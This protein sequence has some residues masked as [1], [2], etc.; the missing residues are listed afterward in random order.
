MRLAG[1]CGL[2]AV[3]PLVAG[4]LGSGGDADDGSLTWTAP[5]SAYAVT[6]GL[7]AP[8]APKLTNTLHLLEGQALGTIKPDSYQPVRIPV[9]SPLGQPGSTRLTVWNFTW[10]ADVGL[11]RGVLDLAVEVQ[12]FVAGNPYVATSG[13]DSCFWFVYVEVFDP[14]WTTVER[15]EH[16][17]TTP[18]G[19]EPAV[20]AE[21]V[22]RLHLPFELPS[23]GFAAGYTA[24]IS[25]SV[26]SY[27]QAP[28]ARID[29]LTGSIPYDSRVTF[30]GVG[31]PV[32]LDRVALLT[33]TA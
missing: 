31:W 25:L 8:D 19:E 16:G 17:N 24:T 29:L 9:Y 30:E 22:R 6:A 13:G 27:G 21:G 18:C 14:A 4:C 33:T 5:P 12:G 11:I 2:L 15:D 20:V 23:T 26:E 1:W 3:V 28:D 10:P 7:P 32:G